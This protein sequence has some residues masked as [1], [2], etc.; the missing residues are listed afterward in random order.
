MKY[1]ETDKFKFLAEDKGLYFYGNLLAQRYFPHLF[2]GKIISVHVS[3]IINN[4]FVLGVKDRYRPLITLVSGQCLK[5][6]LPVQCAIREIE[7]ETGVRADEITSITE[8]NVTSYTKDQYDHKFSAQCHRYVIHATLD[9]TRLR[10]INT[11]NNEEIDKVVILQITQIPQPEKRRKRRK[12]GKLWWSPTHIKLIM[13][14][15]TFIK[16]SPSP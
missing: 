10:E 16:A 4:K 8:T 1:D 12:A 15:I 3:I 11:Y 13:E 7:E 6:E 14:D 2:E 5:N 9:K